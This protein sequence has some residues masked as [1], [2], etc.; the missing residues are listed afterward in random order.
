MNS[1]AQWTQNAM[2]ETTA[3]DIMQKCDVAGSRQLTYM[4]EKN[5]DVAGCDNWRFPMACFDNIHL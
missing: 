4:S 3:A 1:I 2:D 5:V